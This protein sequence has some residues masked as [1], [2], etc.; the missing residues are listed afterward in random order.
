VGLLER[1]ERLCQELRTTDEMLAERRRILEALVDIDRRLRAH[2]RPPP[3]LAH[4]PRPTEQRARRRIVLAGRVLALGAL[5]QSV[6][7]MLVALGIV[8]LTVDCAPRWRA[9]TAPEGRAFGRPSDA[10]T[11]RDAESLRAP[12]ESRLASALR[13]H[14]LFDGARP[15]ALEPGDLEDPLVHRAH[16]VEE[17]ASWGCMAASEPGPTDRR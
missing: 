1:R 12:A 9:T 3:I 15:L 10:S 8:A 2:E 16:D 11:S 4:P 17:P 7:L 13:M 5:A 14:A 6:M